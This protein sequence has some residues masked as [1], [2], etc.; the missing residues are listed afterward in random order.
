MNL[1]KDHYRFRAPAKQS[2]PDGRGGFSS[3]PRGRVSPDARGSHGHPGGP[4][5][6]PLSGR[7]L[8]PI[9]RGLLPSPRPGGHPRGRPRL[10][11]R[12]DGAAGRTSGRPHGGI[13]GGTP[14]PS[15]APAR[16]R[17]HSEPVKP[18]AVRRLRSWPPSARPRVPNS[19]PSSGGRRGVQCLLPRT[20]PAPGGWE[21]PGVPVRFFQKPLFS[22]CEL[23]LKKNLRLKNRRPKHCD[24]S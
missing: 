15:D 22:V 24:N 7:G 14:N 20:A 3:L 21:R 1:R 18:S 8:A 19:P 4:Q 10:A 11:P 6:T 9:G 12:A 17:K 16:A 13:G 23:W 2:P 5:Q